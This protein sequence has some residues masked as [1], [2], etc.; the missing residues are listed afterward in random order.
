VFPYQRKAYSQKSLELH[1]LKGDLIPYTPIG[2]H[3][4]YKIDRHFL[5]KFCNKWFFD[6]DEIYKHCR[7]LHL[8][9]HICDTGSYSFYYSYE[10][11]FKHFKLSHYVCFHKDCSQE[12]YTNI[13]SNF[14]QLRNHMS[15]EHNIYL[16][17]K[18]IKNRSKNQDHSNFIS[19]HGSNNSKSIDI[20]KQSN[21]EDHE[22]ALAQQIAHKMEE[23]IEM[24][25]IEAQIK[26][27]ESYEESFPSLGSSCDKNIYSTSGQNINSNLNYKNK[28]LKNQYNPTDYSDTLQKNVYT[29]KDWNKDS[30]KF[31]GVLNNKQPILLEVKTAVDLD[32]EDTIRKKKAFSEILKT[33]Q[34]IDE[35]N[36]EYPPGL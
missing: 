24:E 26:N 9:C 17:K 10:D 7:S 19:F 34:Q 30:E 8:F 27:L 3:Y 35:D 21:L 11:L 25:I 5:C 12:L 2:D 29:R 4:G 18:Y 16:K 22:N 23:I 1:R 20:R 14:T 33:Y 15:S 13:F 36:L 28:A 31:T 32:I 6:M